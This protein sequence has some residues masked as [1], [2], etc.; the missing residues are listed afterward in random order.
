[1]GE[2]AL[3]L[4]GGQRQKLALARALL[5]KPRLLIL[6]EPTNH[7]DTQAVTMVMERLSA[8]PFKPAILIISH[9]LEVVD[10]A[11]FVY[12]IQEDTI[13]VVKKPEEFSLAEDKV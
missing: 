7:L 3:F 4:S 12:E 13:S 11:D 6:D 8:L 1:V 5:K 10:L 9:E 2:F